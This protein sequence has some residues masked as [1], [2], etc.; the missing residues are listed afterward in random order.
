MRRRSILTAVALVFVTSSKNSHAQTADRVVRVGVLQFG[1]LTAERRRY[2][3]GFRQELR[4][5]GWDESRNLVLDARYADGKPDRLKELA[6]ALT[7]TKPNLIVA[8]G[9]VTT[10]WALRV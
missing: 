2:Y 9:G 7:A 5:L 1:E 8:L 3:E 6:T 4:S 10:V